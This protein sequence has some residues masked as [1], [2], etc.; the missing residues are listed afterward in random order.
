M[1]LTQERARDRYI[2]IM[3]NAIMSFATGTIVGVYVA[4]NY[5]VPNVRYAVDQAKSYLE[6]FEET[7]R[8]SSSKK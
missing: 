5:R 7:N 1:A 6:E 2:A 4:Q 8:K 3:F